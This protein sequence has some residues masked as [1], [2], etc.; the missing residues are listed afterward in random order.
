MTTVTDL[1][2]SSMVERIF[3]R[4]N[5]MKINSISLLLAATFENRLCYLQ[6]KQSIGRN[7]GLTQLHCYMLLLGAQSKI[8]QRRQEVENGTRKKAIRGKIKKPKR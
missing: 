3:S 8:D 2:Y 5:R 7:L 4:I 6:S 1:P